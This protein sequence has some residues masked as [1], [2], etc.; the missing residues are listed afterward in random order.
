MAEQKEEIPPPVG[1]EDEETPGYKAP[2]PRSLGEIQNLDQED[3]S[4]N[5]YKNTL[6]GQTTDALIGT[7]LSINRLSM[8][9]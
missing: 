5:K 6:L 2:A 1:E 9:S 3:E 8:R 4:L 7:C